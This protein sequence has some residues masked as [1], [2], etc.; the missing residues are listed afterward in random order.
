M[1]RV[2]DVLQVD[3]PADASQCISEFAWT[4]VFFPLK[5]WSLGC[6]YAWELIVCFP[7]RNLREGGAGG[8]KEEGDPQ[9]LFS[10]PGCDCDFEGVLPEICDAHGRCLCRPGVEGPRCAACRRG[11]YSFPICQGERPRPT[12][13]SPGESSPRR[14]AAG[15]VR[16]RVSA[17][18]ISHLCEGKAEAVWP[19]CGPRL[20]N[21]NFIL[22]R[23]PS[24]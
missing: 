12:S 16:P 24:P 13:V 23:Q 9:S 5:M 15:A 17:P 21:R 1:K 2:K 11:F 19:S 6:R 18:P 10:S 8:G 7:D 22:T 14:E 20:L 4:L 3:A